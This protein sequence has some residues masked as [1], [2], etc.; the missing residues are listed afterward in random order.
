MKLR[1]VELFCGIGGFAA[2]VAGGNVEVVSAFDQNDAA[3]QVYRH[4]FPAHGARRLDLERVSAAELAACVAGLWWLSPPCQPYSVRGRQRDLD[5]PRA[6][7]LVRLLD[8]LEV[9]PDGELPRHLALENVPGFARSLARER[10]LSVL[11]ARGF[12][13]RERTLCPTELGVPSRRP[14]YYLVASRAGLRPPEPLSPQPLRQL[15]DYLDQRICAAPPEE[16]RVPDAVLCRFGGGF[17]L[18]DPAAPGSYTTCFTAG[19][20]KSLMHAGAYLR[21]PAGVRRFAP[22]EIARLLHFPA[23]FGFPANMTLRRRW[24]LVG[25]SLSVIAVREVLRDLPGVEVGGQ[26]QLKSPLTFT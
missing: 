19:Y 14:R 4:N 8:I 13:V 25:N 15:A 18:L 20:G 24:H 23:A 2:A 7:S 16:L 1:A 22:E 5:D 10:L 21:T 17:R 6:R 26:A 9:L 11:A 3:L 12:E